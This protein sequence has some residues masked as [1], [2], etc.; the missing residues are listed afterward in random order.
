MCLACLGHC[1][2]CAP[3][4]AAPGLHWGL[5]CWHLVPSVVQDEAEDPRRH[6][7]TVLECP[8]WGWGLSGHRVSWGSP[9]AAALPRV[10]GSVG[11]GQCELGGSSSC[12]SAIL[13]WHTAAYGTWPHRGLAPHLL[14]GMWQRWTPTSHL[15]FQGVWMEY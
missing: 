11:T 15:N 13:P 8:G 14:W 10:R 6:C 5:L 9:R 7:Q 2:C 12:S 3:S 1:C 4:K